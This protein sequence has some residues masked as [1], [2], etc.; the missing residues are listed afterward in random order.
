MQIQTKQNEIVLRA[1]NVADGPKVWKL[2][3]DSQTLD[4]N[5][6][7]CYLVLFKHFPDT[8]VVAEQEKNLIGFVTAYIPPASPN[9][10]FIWQIGIQPIMKEKGLGK[11]LITH[12]LKR[13]VCQN[14][15]FI[16]TTI[17]PNNVASK[18]LFHALPR[19]LKTA[20]MESSGFPEDLFPEGNHPAEYLY[21]I[22][23]FDPNT[24]EH[25]VLIYEN[26]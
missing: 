22:G 21:R 15:S 24:I 17:T 4:L 26:H 8:C 5:S 1:P 20:C 2:V 12:L 9:V 13:P 3:K 18:A 16:E 19:T 7:Y 11:S 10:L 23:P 6:V 25:E 14:I